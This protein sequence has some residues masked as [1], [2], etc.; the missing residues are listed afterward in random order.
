MK[1]IAITELMRKLEVA[2]KEKD[3][4]QLTVEK[5]KN[6]SK[7]LNK[8]IDSQIIDNCKKGLGSESY[9]AVLPPY[10]GNFMPLKP[11]LSF[12]GLDE[13]AIKL[14]VSDDE[15]VNVAQPN[16]VKKTVKPSIVKKEFVKPRQQEKIARKTVKKV[17]HNMQNTHRPRDNQRNWNNMMSQ[18]LRSNFEMFNK[19]CYNM[20][21][22]IEDMLL[23]EGT[24]KEGKSQENVPLKLCLV[25]TDDYSRFT[26]VF[27]LSTKDETSGILKSFI[28]RIKNLV[29]RKVKVI[30]CDNVTEFKNKEMNQFCKMKGIMRQ[31]SVARTLQ[32]NGVAERRNKTL[33][34]AARTMLTDFKLP[35]TF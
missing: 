30:R 28:T 14:V 12:T 26:W 11:D 16:I 24:S 35:T 18:K 23:L 8:L 10:I 32:Q 21:K 6:A 25:V 13:F 4:I 31:F 17:K 27:F 3:G 1:E 29:D 20:K 9:N 2:Q 22:L 7:S 15:E 34:E 5:L 19:A 33:I